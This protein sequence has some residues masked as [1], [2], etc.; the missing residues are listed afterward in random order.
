MKNATITEDVMVEPGVG[1]RCIG[2]NTIL[3]KVRLALDGAP[4]GRWME[5][6]RRAFAWMSTASYFE[7]LLEGLTDTPYIL[8]PPLRWTAAV[9]KELKAVEQAANRLH[10]D[11]ERR[12][13]MQ[14]ARNWN[15]LDCGQEGS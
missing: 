8:P 4:L 1:E 6:L 12:H 5:L 10:V 7:E 15:M 9:H 3:L 14:S 2:L 11:T 13:G